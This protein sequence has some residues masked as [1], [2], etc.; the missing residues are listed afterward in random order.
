MSD[1][2][3]ESF[4]FYR[5]FRDAIDEMS[6]ADKLETLLAICDY[7]LYGEEPKLKGAMPRAV[8]TIAKPSID[9]A[10][11]KRTSGKRGGRPPKR[12]TNGFEEKNHWFS[13]NESTDTDTDTGTDTDTEAG[14]D[15][16]A[17]PTAPVPPADKVKKPVRKEYGQYGWVKLSDE[18]YNRLLNDLGETEVKRCIAHVDESAQSSGNKNRW[19]DWNLVIRRCHRDHWG[20][21][22][23][24]GKPNA[25]SVPSDA[26]YLAGWGDVL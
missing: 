5:S 22:T 25:R 6:D 14:T 19:R 26:D 17:E 23:V 10:Q 21:G 7:A 12:K 24:A 3:F 11:A 20:S 9:V 2:P 4:I 15:A 18:E 1:Y 8:Y 13:E 16:P